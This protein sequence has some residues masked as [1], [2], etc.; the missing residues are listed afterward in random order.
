MLLHRQSKCH[1]ESPTRDTSKWIIWIWDKTKRYNQDFRVK[2]DVPADALGLVKCLCNIFRL[3]LGSPSVLFVIISL[4]IIVVWMYNNVFVF[5]L[6]SHGYGFIKR[7]FL[8]SMSDY[9]AYHAHCSFMIVKKPKLNILLPIKN[10]EINMTSSSSICY[11]PSQLCVVL[12]F[13]NIFNFNVNSFNIFTKSTFSCLS[14]CSI[15]FL[16]HFNYYTKPAPKTCLH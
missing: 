5:V 2:T 6:G 13:P 10:D 9:L 14:C 15:Y 12:V 4:N 1:S 16:L 7:V 3:Y 8:G 11:H